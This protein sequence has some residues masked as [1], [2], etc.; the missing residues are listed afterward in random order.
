MLGPPGD[1]Y[2]DQTF[3]HFFNLYSAEAPQGLMHLLAAALHPTW[4]FH[5]VLTH[6]QHRLIG[7]T[8]LIG[9]MCLYKH[10]CKAEKTY[11]YVRITAVFSRNRH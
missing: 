4:T 9:N 1:T 5:F 8:W 2:L 7:N 3:L 6:I 10:F 11:L